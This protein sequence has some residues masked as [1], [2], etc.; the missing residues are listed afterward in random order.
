MFLI[1]QIFEQSIFIRVSYQRN[2]YKSFT[3][4][5]ALHPEELHLG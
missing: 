5:N 2:K 3:Q 4:N 1:V